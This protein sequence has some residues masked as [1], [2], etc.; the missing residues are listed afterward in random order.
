[1]GIISNVNSL[2]SSLSK[3]HHPKAELRNVKQKLNKKPFLFTS[4]CQTSS[5]IIGLLNRHFKC[6]LGKPGSLK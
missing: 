6:G 2:N 5:L 3:S 1:M 4:I